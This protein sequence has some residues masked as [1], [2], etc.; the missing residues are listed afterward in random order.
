MFCDRPAIGSIGSAALD[1]PERAFTRSSFQKSV[2]IVM[3]VSGRSPEQ[4]AFRMNHQIFC[5]EACRVRRSN[6]CPPG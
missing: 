3:Q 1:R 6:E 4:L 5:N 2:G